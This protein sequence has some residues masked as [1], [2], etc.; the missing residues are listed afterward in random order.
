[1]GV[2]RG[3]YDDPASLRAALAGIDALFLLTAP[4]APGPGERYGEQTIGAAHD[5]ADQAVRASGMR[6][7]LLRPTTFASTRWGGP[8][9]SRRGRRSPTCSAPAGRGWSTHPTSPRSPP[10]C[11]LHHGRP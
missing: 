7:T 11:S 2:V 5:T 3:D 9:R 6:W 10:R 8:M 4:S 1:V